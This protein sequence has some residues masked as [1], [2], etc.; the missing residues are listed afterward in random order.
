MHTSVRKEHPMAGQMA[1]LATAILMSTN[2]LFIKLLPW[3]PM[4]ITSIRSMIALVFLLT[5]RLISPPPKNAKNPPI[6]LITAAVLFVLT[7]YSF[8]I[9]NKLTTAANAIVLQY[10]AP[11][12]AALLGWWLIKEKPFPEHWGALVFIFAGLALFL[13]D[14]LGR[15]SL[16][17]DAL[18]VICGICWGAYSVFSRML[19]NGNPGDAL[20]LAHLIGAV[21]GIP[22][23]F[24]YPPSISPSSVLSILYMGIF[25][26]GLASLF[27]AY[28]LKRVSAVQ[29]MLIST[30]EPLLNPIWVLA[31]T[32][33]RPTPVALIGGAI[34]ISAVLAS[35]L[36]GMRRENLK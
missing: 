4:V 33:E 30:T 20:L 36:I 11:I 35:S 15:G 34:I 2:G 25:Q 3:H 5:V 17:G 31:I 13:W 9:A 12:W 7:M 16:L 22:F 18:A 32:G 24:L 19:K 10:T 8:I 23:I 14:G 26:I 1:I 29:T 28:G 27:L 21:V 6:P